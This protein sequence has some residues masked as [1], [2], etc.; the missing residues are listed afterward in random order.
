M[1]KYLSLLFA[2]LSINAH[3]VPVN[4]QSCINN[5]VCFLGDISNVSTINGNLITS[6]DFFDIR[7]GSIQQ[8]TLT[9]YQLGS[10]SVID[11]VDEHGQLTQTSIT[12]SIWLEVQQQYSLSDS[13]H[14]LSLHFDETTPSTILDVFRSSPTAENELHM[15]ISTEGL[16][17]G[18]G[19]SRVELDSIL[20]DGPYSLFSSEGNRLLP[21]CLAGGCFAEATL[22]LLTLQYLNFGDSINLVTPHPNHQEETR[23]LLFKTG[24]GY[25]SEYYK[26]YSMASVPLP[27]S[28]LLFISG[29]ALFLFRLRLKQTPS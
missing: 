10:A 13:L 15:Q 6:Y 24:I 18:Q 12:G 19:A 1:K 2:L 3:A 27:P 8:K 26:T 9:E 22:N 17:S 23:E 25:E 11:D 5:G 4:I 16:L 28:L 21:P 14:S 20:A 29:G 7:S